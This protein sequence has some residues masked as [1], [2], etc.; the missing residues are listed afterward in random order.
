[1][2][3]EGGGKEEKRK[4]KPLA[5]CDVIDCYPISNHLRLAGDD[6]SARLRWSAMRLGTSALG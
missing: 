1:M 4:I 6:Y 3:E 5:G 2:F